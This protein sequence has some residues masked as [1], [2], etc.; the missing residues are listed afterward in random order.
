M[1]LAA[2][3]GNTNVTLGVF[4]GPRLLGSWRLAT[5]PDKTPDEYGVA[6]SALVGAGGRKPG[7]FIYG[8]V[9]PPLDPTFEALARICF[10]LKARR[11]DN[12]SPLGIRLKVD[13]PREVGTDRLLNA[14]AVSRLYGGPAVVL[15]FGTATTFDCVSARGDYL[16]GAILVGPKVA[17]KALA[18]HTAQLPEVEIRKPPRWIG[19]NTEHCIQSGLYYGYLGM[20]EKVLRGTIRE[21]GSR[22][23]PKVVVTG[24]LGR[25]FAAELP[26]VARLDPDLTLQ[27][28]RLAHEIL[29]RA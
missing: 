3:V 11:V 5:D 27:G 17:A 6:V 16:G 15:D 19:K 2:D 25:F 29:E 24:G 18:E 20:V 28:L 4:E 1:L 26:G 9:V 8:S 23:R 21:M 22:R 12:R 7:A 13:R 14:L 10:G